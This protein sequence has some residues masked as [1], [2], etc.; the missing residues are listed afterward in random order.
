MCV[1]TTDVCINIVV[2]QGVEQNKVNFFFFFLP[3]RVGFGTRGTGISVHHSLLEPI[4]HPPRQGQQK[5]DK[6]II[7]FVDRSAVVLVF[8]GFDCAHFDSCV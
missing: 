2:K 4:R 3:S 5:E 7:A 8:M 6:K 1:C